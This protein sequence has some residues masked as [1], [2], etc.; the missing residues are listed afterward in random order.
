MRQ[1]SGAG[2]NKARG[3]VMR[4][5]IG[6]KLRTIERLYGV[7]RSQ[8]RAPEGLILEGSCKQHVENEIIRRVSGLSDFL[9]D[10]PV[11]ADYLFRLES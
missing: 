10:D 8:N 11:L 2:K 5:H 1:P 3:A 9:Y 4:V 7:R 6:F